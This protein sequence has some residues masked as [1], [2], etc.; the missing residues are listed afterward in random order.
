MVVTV[1][2]EKRVNVWMETALQE[3]QVRSEIPP[4]RPFSLSHLSPHS[5]LPPRERRIAHVF[6]ETRAKGE[7]EM[8]RWKREREIER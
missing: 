3:T 2:Q 6:W 4:S 8:E 5:T 1:G 7:R